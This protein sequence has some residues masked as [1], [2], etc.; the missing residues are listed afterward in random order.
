LGGTVSAT[1]GATTYNLKDTGKLTVGTTYFYVVYA[2]NSTTV[3]GKPA[4]TSGVSNEAYVKVVSTAGSAPT[5]SPPVLNYIHPA[6]IDALAGMARASG[7]SVLYALDYQFNMAIPSRLGDEAAYAYAAL[8]TSLQGFEI[9]NE[10]DLYHDYFAGGGQYSFQDFINQWNT[11]YT[12]INL[13]AATKNALLTGP[14]SCCHWSGAGNWPALFA[15]QEPGKFGLLTGHYY[16]NNPRANTSSAATEMTSLLQ[17][18]SALANNLDV[19]ATAAAT[20]GAGGSA[21]PFRVSEANSI[22]QGGISGVSDAYGSAL[23]IVDFLFANVQHGSTGINLH[24]GGAYYSP[25]MDAN[26]NATSVRPE[27]YGAY[28]FYDAVKGKHLL[29][30]T[31][32]SAIPSTLSTYAAIAGSGPT[33]IFLNNKDA[34]RSMVI[35]IVLPA[36]ATT[37]TRRILTDS[38]AAG[39]LD[40]TMANISINGQNIPANSAWT[41]PTDASVPVLPDGSIGITVP[42]ASVVVVTAN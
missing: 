6:D 32:S 37:A 30:T 10:P 25:I 12:A 33:S 36:K 11:F 20:A 23:W 24:G 8:G 42:P 9:G 28:L 38:S 13:P 39:L 27:F 40:T 19:L 29:Q 4:G 22:P 26:G 16:N 2:N 17:T 21:I 1:S 31:N 34:T 14:A 3:A 5:A 35:K 7:W 41:P 15:Q 18:D